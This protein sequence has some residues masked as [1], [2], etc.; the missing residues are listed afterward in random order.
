VLV[1]HEHD[2]AEFAGRIVLFRDG[3]VVSDREHP[4]RDA[5]QALRALAP[6]EPAP[7]PSPEPAP[8]P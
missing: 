4:A 6:A 1:T 7:G 2:I 3:R 8:A 5:A